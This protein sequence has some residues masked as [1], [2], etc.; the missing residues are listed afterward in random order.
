MWELQC[1]PG[2]RVSDLSRALSIHQST[3][4]N[5]LDKLEGKGLVRRE[6]GGPDHRVVR[7][8]LTD[9]GTA[10]VGQAPR[11]ARGALS[12]A[13]ERLSDAELSELDRGLGRLVDAMTIQDRAAALRPLSDN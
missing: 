12:E 6:R 9:A 7:L 11:P 13:L 5:L 10:L 4:S 1:T 8:F 3:T 2:V